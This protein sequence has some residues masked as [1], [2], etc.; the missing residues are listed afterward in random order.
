MADW[1][2]IKVVTFRSTLRLLVLDNILKAIDEKKLTT[3]VLMD[4]SKAFDCM[5]HDISLQKPKLLGTSEQAC[6]CFKSY[7]N[8]RQQC[9]RV[10]TSTLDP[11]IVALWI[12]QVGIPGPMLFGLF[13][14]DL[15]TAVK[16]SNSES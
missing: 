2:N 12:P 4:L 6:M 9:T 11:L 16:H 5:I 7:L 14:N 3:M 8:N 1:L 13:L 10:G 15:P